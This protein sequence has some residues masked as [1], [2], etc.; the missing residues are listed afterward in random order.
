MAAVLMLALVPAPIAPE[1]VALGDSYAAGT[2]A[3]RDSCDRS[4]NAYGALYAKQ[5]HASFV[6]AA[7]SGATAK[8]VE[9]QL[10]SI[11]PAATLVTLTVGGNDIGFADV[12]TTCTLQSEKSCLKAVDKA[13][14]LTAETLP[15]RLDRLY[16]KLRAT[17]PA[18]VVV[19]GYPH[20][21][22]PTGACSL[23]KAERAALNS[24]ADRL[25]AVIEARSLAAGFTFGDVRTTFAGHGLCGPSPWI[26]GVKFPVISS[27][28]PN[29]KGQRLGYLPVLA[30]ARSLS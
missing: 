6:M 12:M 14:K 11:T 28:H 29:A 18:K 23:S 25:N 24:A 21:F 9:S 30:A 16:S 20:L 13:N 19:L 1:L 26:N 8:S 7:C 22:E 5:I 10:K 15:G 27:Y 4:S 3:S 17:T 2:G